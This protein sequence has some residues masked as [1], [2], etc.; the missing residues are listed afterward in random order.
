MDE[1]GA[2]SPVR[3]RVGLVDGS[4]Q[5]STRRFTVVLD[6]DAVVQLDE[7]V[8]TTQELPDGRELT[9]YGIVVEGSGQIEGAAFASDTARIARDGTM[10]GITARRAEVQVLRTVPELWLAPEP[11]APVRRAQPSSSASAMKACPMETSDKPGIFSL[12]YFKLSRFR[13]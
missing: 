4:V 9:H 7:L 10:P 1:N 6:E 13:S 5:A 8:A 12:K 11:G 3:T 2:V